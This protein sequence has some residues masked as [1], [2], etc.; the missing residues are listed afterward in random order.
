MR[1]Q[2][3][4]VS[5]DSF[6]F[7]AASLLLLSLSIPRLST[8]GIH[9][10][11]E[12]C[13][14]HPTSLRT[15][16]PLHTYQQPIISQPFNPLTTPPLSFSTPSPS[17]S[18]QLKYSSLNSL[19]FLPHPANPPPPRGPLNPILTVLIDPYNQRTLQIHASSRSASI[20]PKPPKSMHDPRGLSNPYP[21]ATRYLHTYLHI[22]PPI[23]SHPHQ[24]AIIH[25][26]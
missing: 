16:S 14:S 19:P 23:P 15:V 24:T 5:R 9:T 1:N 8:F 13:P 17:N 26:A 7:P 20:H 25:S 2:R 3:P 6:Y 18:S 10:F 4:S 22:H 21:Q 12:K 11:Q